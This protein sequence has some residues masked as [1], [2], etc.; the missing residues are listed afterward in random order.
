VHPGTC[1]IPV[2]NATADALH[3]DALH[4]RLRRHWVVG[5]GRNPCTA[6]NRRMVSCRFRIDLPVDELPAREPPLHGRSPSLGRTTGPP[7]CWLWQ[8]NG[9]AHFYGRH[10]WLQWEMSVTKVHGRIESKMRAGALR[11]TGA[12]T[13]WAAF[14]GG[15]A[16]GECRTAA[17]RDGGEDDRVGI[18]QP[19]D[20]LVDGNAEPSAACM[21]SKLTSCRR[22]RWT[23]TKIDGPVGITL[24]WQPIPDH[25]ETEAPWIRPVQGSPAQRR[26]IV[27]GG[28]FIARELRRNPMR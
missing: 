12:F 14:V 1:N 20:G 5:F 28:F 17:A 21:R 3:A 9:Q 8:L 27:G 7:V 16:R 25:I 19:W 10:S 24:M 2:S 11:S 13:S 22:Y 4:L 18:P 23:F 26:L 6:V 15:H